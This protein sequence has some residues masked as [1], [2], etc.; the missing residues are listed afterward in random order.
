MCSLFVHPADFVLVDTVPGGFQGL[1]LVHVVTW[2]GKRGLT[3]KG[4]SLL[5]CIIRIIGR[6]TVEF[7]PFQCSWCHMEAASESTD[8]NLVK[9]LVN[10]K[11]R[12]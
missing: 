6:V 12:W 7:E 10:L 3:F 4:L 1:S 11:L 8:N 9:F 5:L 2:R